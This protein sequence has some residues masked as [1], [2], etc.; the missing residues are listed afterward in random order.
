MF[1]TMKQY[2]LACICDT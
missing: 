2:V 1:K